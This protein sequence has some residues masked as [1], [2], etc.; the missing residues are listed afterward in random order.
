MSK[1]MI[2][3]VGGTN[4]RV[5]LFDPDSGEISG[6]TT[7]INR[8]YSSLD[9]II[10]EWMADLTEAAPTQACIAI[11]APP[12]ADIVTMANIDW[13][14]SCSALA[15]KFG[16][17][18]F[19]RIND[20][21]ANAFALPHLAD[22][23]R[24]LLHPGGATHSAKLAVIGPGTGLGGATLETVASMSHVCP[25]EPGYMSISPANELEVEIFRTLLRHY[26]QIYGELLVSGPGLLRIYKTLGQIS[27]KATDA[28][29]PDEVSEQALV[30]R[31][32]LSLLSLETFSGLLGSLAGDFVLATGAYGGLYLAGGI[33]PG[34]IDFLWASD[35]HKRFCDKGAM[36]E[37]M[38][39]VPI[40]AITAAQPGLIG[41]AHTP[42]GK[43]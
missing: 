31:D 38:N 11:A 32:A 42:L 40:Y 3:D 14:F 18:K 23:D 7:F 35:F 37:N 2:A 28:K 16:F 13:S 36:R 10:A 33:L 26:P 6:L 8:H 27:D 34:M 9:N 21:E 43:D 4:T 15:E 19:R 24:K 30:H 12:S 41:A 1:R 20:F 39:A 25:C 5:A 17:G 29:S 22:G